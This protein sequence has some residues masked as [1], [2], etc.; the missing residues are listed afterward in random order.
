MNEI[1][2]A[3]IMASTLTRS[4]QLFE[5]PVHTA[6]SALIM[7]RDTGRLIYFKNPD[8]KRY[9]A[10]TTKIMTALLLLENTEPED[11]IVAPHDVKSVRGSSLNLEPGERVSADDMLYALMIRSAND[12]SYAVAKH[13]SGSVSKFS[14]LMNRRAKEIGCTGTRF[15]NPHGLNDDKHVTTARDLA[16]M[17]REAMNNLDFARAVGTRERWITRSVN[18]KDLLIKSKNK[19]LEIDPTG[20]G[21]KTGWTNPAGRCFVGSAERNDIRLISVVLKS[22]DWVADTTSL[23]EWAYAR[24]TR[25]PLVEAGQI[26]AEMDVE[27]EPERKLKVAA[28]ETLIDLVPFGEAASFKVFPNR[29][30]KLRAPI[31][32]GTDL[33]EATIV[34]PD[35]SKRKLKIS[36]AESI[37]P[38]QTVLGIVQS[39]TGLFFLAVLGGGAYWMRA[40]AVAVHRSLDAKRIANRRTRPTPPVHRSGR[41]L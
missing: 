2:V 29:K 34:F 41:R 30:E 35:G 23:M 16:L 39:P 22:E 37:A 6:A 24:F 15:N 12:G 4:G 8:V 7:D 26:V 5:A 25:G 3:A 40:R 32:A 13:I 1:F 9:P 19:W 28:S 31:A 36:A 14:E 18:Q 38:S 20:N 21:I 33:G 11:V 17:G 27:G 10:S